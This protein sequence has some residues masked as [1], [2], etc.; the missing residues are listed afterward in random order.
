MS[1]GWTN[2]VF[3]GLAAVA[4]A[5][6]Y[7]KGT[8]TWAPIIW[9]GLAVAWAVYAATSDEALTFC[10]IGSTSFGA[11]DCL[12]AE[13]GLGIYAIG[14][15]GAALLLGGL[16]LARRTTSV[17]VPVA[18][19]TTAASTSMHRECPFCKE[20]MR[21]DAGTCPHCRQDSP[22]WTFHEQRWWIATEEDNWLWLDEAAEEWRPFSELVT[23]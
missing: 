8:R 15:G 23:T 11:S 5:R 14:G 10:P 9:G 20:P 13:P 17:A 6:A 22:A 7:Q 12:V 4:I 16:F 1:Y 18:T 19:G 3:S 2:L 21:R